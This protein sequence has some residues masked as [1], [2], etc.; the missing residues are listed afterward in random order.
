MKRA[1]QRQGFKL[2]LALHGTVLALVVVSSLVFRVW[3]RHRPNPKL[4]FVEFTVSVP[5]PPAPETPEP[6]QPD[7]APPPAPKPDEIP[8]PE[9]KPDVKPPAPPKPPPKDIRQTNRVVRKGPPPKDKP[10]SA[11]E[12]ERL[13]KLGAKIGETTQIP[14]DNQLALGAYFNHVH[15]RMYA[16]WQQPPQLKSLPGLSTE[17]SITVEPGGRITAR[18]KIRG[19]GND[20]MDE[21]VMAAVH[22][23]KALR[24][25]PA[26]LRR[27][28]DIDITFELGP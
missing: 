12:I 5:P 15:E 22:A 6:P 10:L 17:V 19:S 21:S 13:L 25:L 8:L 11:A 20:L 1:Y 14:D 28:V 4:M 16:I 3:N 18:R 9:K 23:V 26:G 27:P 24:P 2:S 7:P